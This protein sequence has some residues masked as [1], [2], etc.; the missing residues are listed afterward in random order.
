MKTLKIACTALIL[1]AGTFAAACS[2]DTETEAA[3]RVEIDGLDEGVHF[4][5]DPEE[6]V[7]FSISANKTWSISK[8][9]LDWLTVS[10]MNGGSKLPATITLTA[11]P[12]DDLERSGELTVYAG[13]HVQ[14]VTVTQD[15]FPIV[16]T[17]TLD[18][19]TDDTLEFEFS[20]LD[21]V[22]FSVYANVAWTALPEELDWAEVSPLSGERK[23][24]TTITVTPSAN[25]GDARQG[26]I[27]FRAEEM[28]PVV[29]TV[30]QTA[31]RDDPLLTVTGFGKNNTI[32]FPEVPEA[33]A[34]LQILCNRSWTVVKEG[35][36]WLTVTPESGTSSP[37]PA[38]ITLTASKNTGKART[39]TLTI[40]P[41]DPALEDV[42]ITVS[43]KAKSLEPIAWWTLT[44]EALKKYSGDN[45]LTGGRMFADKPAGTTA[46]G[47]WNKVNDAPVYDPG[48]VISSDGKGHYAVKSVWTDDNLEFTI[49]VKNFAAGQAVNIRYGARS[50][51]TGARYWIVEYFDQGTWKPTSTKEYTFS[52]NGLHVTATYELTKADKVENI[53]E[54]ARFTEAVADGVIRFRIRCVTGTCTIEGKVIAQPSSGAA[55]RFCQWS[56]GDHDAIAFYLVD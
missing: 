21:P 6:G 35:L 45:W 16:P 34:A 18:G 30:R 14:R 33:P 36:D 54:T 12:N 23:K 9:G 50:K 46:Y 27:T 24:R 17:L 55:P 22:T 26:T 44:D 8:S 3:D 42:V 32:E 25:G 38:D 39:G 53:N 19:L 1:L 15:A 7:S 41:D 40:H 47:Q 52:G 43:Q 13:A 37:T 20:D 56:T 2:S 49:P 10:Q 31:Y 5:Y 48:Y 51:K 4:P 11:A 29:V 28:E